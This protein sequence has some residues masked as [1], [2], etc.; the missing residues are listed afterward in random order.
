[1]L[2][3]LIA[4]TLVAAACVAPSPVTD[5]GPP[6]AAQAAVVEIAWVGSDLAVELDG[7]PFT[8]FHPEGPAAPHLH[9]L[10]APGGLAV[11]RGFPMEL[12]DGAPREGESSDHPHHRS[13][14]LAHGDLNGHDFWH[15]G[16]TRIELTSIGHFGDQ[17]ES[18]HAWLAEGVAIAAEQRTLTF[19]AGALARWI[20]VVVRLTPEGVPLTFGDTKEGTFAL[21]L[22]PTL[23]VVGPIA[24]GRLLDSEGREDGA[25]WGQ[26]AR[27][28]AALGPV[29][30]G[31]VTVAVFDAPSN[32]R[33][34]TTWHARE[35][36]LLA[37]NPFGLAAFEGA[38]AGAG[39]VVV[40]DE[41]TLRY[42][43]WLTAH[44]AEP[45]ELEAAWQAYAD[46]L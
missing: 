26:R 8:R 40:E 44:Q 15:G 24:A 28:V 5:L 46:S 25:I 17:I 34:P 23:R 45:E 30:G 3:S 11:T 31:E 29:P 2:R 10:L 12:V 21:R 13:L 37:A 42:R 16:D 43:V 33:H 36:G 38:P 27:W 9:P 18:A 1:M 4:L 41:L 14:W 19:G 39:A 7:Q 32:P 22:A 20:D 6:P 35:Y